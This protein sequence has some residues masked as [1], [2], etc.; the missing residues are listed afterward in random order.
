MKTDYE[1]H[2]WFDSFEKKNET[3][4]AEL[5]ARVVASIEAIAGTREGWTALGVLRLTDIP[6]HVKLWAVLRE[7]LIPA[8]TLNLFAC[9]CAEDALR[10]ADGA[11]DERS[12]NAVATKQLWIERKA[13]DEELRAARD[14][15]IRAEFE[16]LTAT[17]TDKVCDACAARD[18]GC[19]S[20][21]YALYAASSASNSAGSSPR[22]SAYDAAGASA[23]SIGRIFARDAACAARTASFDVDCAALVSAAY[24]SALVFAR[25]EAYDSQVK[26]LL[27]LLA[28]ER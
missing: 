10:R 4:F 16:A 12:W 14:A 27:K 22:N 1:A 20:A 3:K 7:E 8:K 26:K 25:D 5:E 15:S 13:S 21:I 28:V 17:A 6:S 9:A 11:A 24:A 2:V 23:R 18:V 19:A